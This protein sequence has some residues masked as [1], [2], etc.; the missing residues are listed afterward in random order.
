MVALFKRA[1]DRILDHLRLQR[2]PDYRPHP[3]AE[4]DCDALFRDVSKRY[5]KI[6]KRLAE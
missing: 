3:K 4:L 5:P 2:R 1:Q 6:M